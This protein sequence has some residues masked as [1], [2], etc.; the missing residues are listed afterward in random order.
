MRS[1]RTMMLYIGVLLRIRRALSLYK[2]YG[3]SALLVFNGTSLF[4]VIMLYWFS[5]DYT[6]CTFNRTFY[7]V[8]ASH[9]S[10][11]YSWN[12]NS[13]ISRLLSFHESSWTNL[14]L[15]IGKLSVCT[16]MSSDYYR[17]FSHDVMLSS[18]MAASIETAI[19]IHICKHLFR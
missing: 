10:N 6:V 19:N 2:V 16:E 4:S 3:K 11:H 18:N 15:Q 17:A 8:S 9:H 12:R 14:L 13:K 1:R 5:V 7:T